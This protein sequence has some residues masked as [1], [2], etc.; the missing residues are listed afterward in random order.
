MKSFF[1]FVAIFSVSFALPLESEDAASPATTE[2]P[3]PNTPS[4]PTDTENQNGTLTV[5][6]RTQSYEIPTHADKGLTITFT[7][8][9]GVG[10]L[11][12]SPKIEN[13]N[14]DKYTSYAIA[15]PGVIGLVSLDT[16][17]L[18]AAG[19]ELT[20]D[21]KTIITYVNVVALSTDFNYNIDWKPLPSPTPAPTTTTT[22]P[23]P[24]TTSSSTMLSPTFFNTLLLI[25]L[26]NY[27]TFSK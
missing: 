3:P 23:P 27:F 1:I 26:Y 6:T 13:T 20:K 21:N 8:Y 9:H 18:T 2:G 12:F 24:V 19:A 25:A 5:G 22:P 4:P 16:T 15:S 7:S 10:A 17:A 11:Y 14:A